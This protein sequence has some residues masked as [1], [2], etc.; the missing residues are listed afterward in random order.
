MGKGG[1]VKAEAAKLPDAGISPKRAQ[2]NEWQKKGGLLY[3][4][5]FGFEGMIT[6]ATTA[7]KNGSKIRRFR[8][9]PSSQASEARV[10]NDP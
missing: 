8:N 7:G 4:A 6:L 9:V 1:T 2:E 10:S 5:R 3:S